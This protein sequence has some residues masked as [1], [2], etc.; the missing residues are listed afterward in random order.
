VLILPGLC[1]YTYTLCFFGKVTQKSN[2]D[3]ATHHLG[4][5]VADPEPTTIIA[6][7]SNVWIERMRAGTPD[8]MSSQAQKRITRNSYTTEGK[9]R[10]LYETGPNET[11]RSYP[12]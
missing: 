8:L 2:K 6:D 11:A 3:G 1:S 10:L 4:Y 12:I 9:R 7:G 5:V